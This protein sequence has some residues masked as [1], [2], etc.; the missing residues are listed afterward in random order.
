MNVLGIGSLEILLI[1]VVAFVFLG[2]ERLIDVA[3][4]LGN[5]VK[6]GRKL[7][8]EMPRIVVE[9]DEIKVVDTRPDR[10]PSTASPFQKTREPEQKAE[11][12]S[13]GPVAFSRQS[14]PRPEQ[15][16]DERG[17]SR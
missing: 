15:P 13:D 8:S 7:A 5:A 14:E 4:F 16:S 2:P 11:G 1:L 6:E 12:D 10:K 3:R 9:D 17:E